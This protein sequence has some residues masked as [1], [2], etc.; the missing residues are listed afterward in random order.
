MRA[1][2]DAAQGN[3]LAIFV[4]GESGSCRHAP[5]T[6]NPD[7]IL[8]KRHLRFWIILCIK[9]NNVVNGFF[10][11]Y[12]HHA[13]LAV[14]KETYPSIGRVGDNI[15]QQ[16]CVQHDTPAFPDI[17]FFLQENGHI[18]VRSNHGHL[19][20]LLVALQIYAAQ[21]LSG[22]AV[23]ND[24]LHFSCHFRQNALFH[25][26]FHAATSFVQDRGTLSHTLP[27]L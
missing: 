9:E 5:D 23:I 15:K 1:Q 17:R 6:G 13:L 4:D 14:H 10:R 22:Y 19:L 7:S 12:P 26:K 18:Y 2:A 21:N 27:T 20:F 24:F 8:R 16:P 11:F 25:F 3:V